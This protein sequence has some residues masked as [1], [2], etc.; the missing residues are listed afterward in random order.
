MP[1]NMY[2]VT[3]PRIGISGRV[4]TEDEVVFGV[5]PFILR[6]AMGWTVKK[7][8]EFARSNGGV[9]EVLE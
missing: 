6:W 2:S 1:D 8:T 4:Y 7:L 3:M 5:E 9:V